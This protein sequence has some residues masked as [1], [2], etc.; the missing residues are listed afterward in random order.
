MCKAIKKFT[1]IAIAM[2]ISP[3]FAGGSN[4]YI[5]KDYGFKGLS[6]A[7]S[8][9]GFYSDS[10]D[11]KKDVDHVVSLKDAHESGAYAWENT[12]KKRFSNNR[13]NLVPACSSVNRSKG[14][15]TPYYF[16]KRSTD[17]KGVDVN[18][19]DNR[20]CKYATR[21]YNVKIKYNLSFAN[22]KREIFAD[23]GITEQSD[24]FE[25]IATAEI[26]LKRI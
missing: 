7:K 18:W 26:S 3:A 2:F 20:W 24:D 4:A 21:Y 1:L 14:S 13:Y 22:N 23:C 12:K 6:F 15:T 17:G 10:Y 11:C 8:T 19:Q 9:A 25:I 16:F 5:R